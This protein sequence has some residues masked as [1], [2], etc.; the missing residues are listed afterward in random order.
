M[1]IGDILTPITQGL[2]ARSQIQEQDRLNQLGGLTQAAAQGGLG[3]EAFKEL[4]GF[5]PSEAASLKSLLKTDDQGLTA[6]FQDSAVFRSLLQSDPTGQRGIQFLQNRVQVG[7]SQRRDMFLTKGL[8]NTALQDP[9]AALREVDSFLSI[10]AQLKG[11]KAKQSFQ[12]G[13][14]GLV[15]DPNVGAFSIDPVAKA[16][17]DELAEK[18]SSTGKID[19]KD[20]QSI[21][22][23]ITGFIKNSVAIRATANDLDKLSKLGTGPAAIAAVF[24]F[25]KAND[26]ESTVREGEFATAEQ[27]A[28]VPAQITNFYN[29]L[30]TGERLTAD[31]IQQFVETSKVLANSAINSST[32]EVNRFLNTFGEDL[33]VKFQRS[34]RK[35]LPDIFNLSGIKGFEDKPPASIARP[36][37]TA[38]G[39]DLSTLSLEELIALRN[40]G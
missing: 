5:S 8:L 28:G 30:I 38:T 23:D 1:A 18:K 9:Q 32:T 22:K 25:M 14:K 7:E 24:K 39:V 37:T 20:K 21:N 11:Q 16:R 35:R 10:P 4:A 33:P 26:P 3:S 29:K 31:Q 40:R 34:V 13:D 15:F 27:S 19:L 36:E 12:K 2:A 6:A 17:F